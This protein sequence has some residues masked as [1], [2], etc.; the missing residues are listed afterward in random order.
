MFGI[1]V[2]VGHLDGVEESAVAINLA[3]NAFQID[4]RLMMGLIDLS[5]ERGEKFGRGFRLPFA[6]RMGEISVV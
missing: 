5:C 1:V 4:S 2:Q 3:G 6:G